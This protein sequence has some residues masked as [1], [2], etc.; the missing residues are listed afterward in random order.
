MKDLSLQNFDTGYGIAARWIEKPGELTLAIE[1]FINCPADDYIIILCAVPQTLS[2]QANNLTNLQLSFIE[3]VNFMD[4]QPC[5]IIATSPPEYFRINC[6]YGYTELNEKGI[7]ESRKYINLS[8]LWNLKNEKNKIIL[9][10]RSSYRVTQGII[11]QIEK[12]GGVN[13]VLRPGSPRICD[14]VA[15]ELL[16]KRIGR[17][18]LVLDTESP[19]DQVLNAALK[20]WNRKP[21]KTAVYLCGIQFIDL[22]G[23]DLVALNYHNTIVLI[24]LAQIY[25]IRGYQSMIK[26]VIKKMIYFLSPKLRIWVASPHI[27]G[28]SYRLVKLNNIEFRKDEHFT[29]ILESVEYID[30]EKR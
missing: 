24:C 14:L 27:R 2:V 6:R 8:Q 4:R 30:A 26:E 16:E 18:V 25:N 29:F 28:R 17:K 1:A 22:N 5:Q 23:E 20:A 10:T 15:K 7:W 9:K 13:F 21:I 3:A 19:V 12:H 11:H